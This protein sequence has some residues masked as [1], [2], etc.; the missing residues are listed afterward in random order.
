MQHIY[1]FNLSDDDCVPREISSST[2]V[3]VGHGVL[4]R[5]LFRRN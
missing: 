3:E 2:S 4:F 5:R 1:D